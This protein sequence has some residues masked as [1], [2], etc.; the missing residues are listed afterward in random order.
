MAGEWKDCPDEVVEAKTEGAVSK[1]FGAVSTAASAVKEGVQSVASSVFGE[2][3]LAEAIPTAA[4]V[5]TVGL[6]L[7]IERKS[8]VVRLAVERRDTVG[9]GL[10]LSEQS[11][12]AR[13][14]DP[15]ISTPGLF[16]CGLLD[17]RLEDQ[18]MEPARRRG[19]KKARII[20]W[21]PSLHRVIGEPFGANLE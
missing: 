7:Q 11:G 17:Q 18:R 9:L 4:K 14:G 2:Q 21:S 19:P 12:G 16:A 10:L 8:A 15:R 13:G 6:D 3:K 5:P 1:L 20:G